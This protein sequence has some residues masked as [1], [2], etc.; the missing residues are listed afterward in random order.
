MNQ[1]SRANLQIGAPRLPMPLRRF[2]VSVVFTTTYVV[3]TGKLTSAQD[4]LGFRYVDGKCVNE[5]GQEGLNPKYPGVCGD[6]EG[7]DLREA[8]LENVDFSG[9][10]MRGARLSAA[11]LRGAIFIGAELRSAD[12]RDADLRNTDFRG[13]DLQRVNFRQADLTEANL[14]EADLQRAEMFQAIM[15]RVSLRDSDLRNSDLR[16]ADLTDADLTK[17]RLRRAVGDGQTLIPANLSYDDLM[18][19]GMLFR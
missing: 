12:L 1:Y 15:R 2:I 9:A 13:A 16:G 10:N 17:T 6:I 3:L 5:S 4:D 14:S 19:R 7:V 18:R 11:K 8:F